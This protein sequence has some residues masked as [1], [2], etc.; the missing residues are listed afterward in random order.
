[1]AADVYFDHS[2][3][4]VNAQEEAEAKLRALPEELTKVPEVTVTWEVIVHDH[5]AA[6]LCEAA[7]RVGA[8]AICMESQGVSRAGALLGSTVIGV[9]GH[10]HR[11]V[12]VVTP[13]LP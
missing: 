5:V 8:D 12:F 1:V 7:D 9:L 6:T 13:P 10:A 3:E 4:T 2:L 11:P